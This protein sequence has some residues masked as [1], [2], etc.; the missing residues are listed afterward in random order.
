MTSKDSR[1]FLNPWLGRMKITKFLFSPCSR[2]T[3]KH[4]VFSSNK[5]INIVLLQYQHMSYDFIYG[6][7]AIINCCFLLFFIFFNL[8]QFHW[9]VKEQTID[10][11]GG[12][13]YQPCLFT[14][15]ILRSF[16]VSAR[17]V[18]TENLQW[19]EIAVISGIKSVWN[20]LDLDF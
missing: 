16:H 5:I 1:N 17:P 14:N 6:V 19:L 2:K 11:S 7:D 15:L 12:I 13:G 20:L 10:M 9:E 3:K 8:K 4:S 18:V